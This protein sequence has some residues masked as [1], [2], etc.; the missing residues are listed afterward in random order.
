MKHFVSP[1]YVSPIYVDPIVLRRIE[2][3]EGIAQ[4]VKCPT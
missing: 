1:T 4:L 3:V 2:C